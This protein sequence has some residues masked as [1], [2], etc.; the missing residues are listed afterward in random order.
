MV[1]CLPPSTRLYVEGGVEE[2]WTAWV[3]IVLFVHMYIAINVVASNEWCAT[4]PLHNMFVTYDP[5][6]LAAY[7]PSCSHNE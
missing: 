5:A 4:T 7:V 2:C 1:F 3:C 6:M